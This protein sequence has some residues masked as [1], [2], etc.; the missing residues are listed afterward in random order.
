MYKGTTV[1]NY[2][3]ATE[4]VVAS[5]TSITSCTTTAITPAL[6]VARVYMIATHVKD[7]DGKDAILFTGGYTSTTKA[8][9]YISTAVDLLTY[10]IVD[11][12]VVYSI[13]SYDSNA[14][15]KNVYT[16]LT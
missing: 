5:Q 11:G 16:Y 10:N 15:V 6:G 4:L 14:A 9:Q 1:Y 8:A 12:K 3:S 13:S 2:I 7:V